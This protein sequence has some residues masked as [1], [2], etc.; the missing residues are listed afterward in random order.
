[1]T[2]GES[3]KKIVKS[4]AEDETFSIT[5]NL[6]GRLKFAKT[7]TR[8]RELVAKMEEHIKSLEILN[9]GQKQISRFCMA[10]NLIVFES[11]RR[12]SR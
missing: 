7:D 11:L 1:M 2:Q 4:H 10:G 9:K 6:T 3:L 5:K 8:R 12:V